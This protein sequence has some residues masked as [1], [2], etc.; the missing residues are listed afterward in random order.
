MG[1]L[2]QIVNMMPGMSGKLK[3][4]DA[5]K[6]EKELQKIES[7]INSMTKAEREKPS[8]INASRKRRI[9]GM[10]CGWAHRG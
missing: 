3:E 5:E 2:Q 4:E 7:M 1:P 6:G 9:A 10:G 8:I